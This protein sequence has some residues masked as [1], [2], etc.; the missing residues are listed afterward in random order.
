M[1]NK[2]FAIGRLINIYK[3]GDGS[4][5]LKVLILRSGHKDA[6]VNFI[7]EGELEEDIRLDRIISIEG[8]VCG[9][10][11]HREDDGLLVERRFLKADKISIAEG[12]MKKFFGIP[13]HFPPEHNLKIY[14]EGILDELEEAGEDAKRIFLKVNDEKGDSYRVALK[15]F[16]H[17]M[18]EKDYELLSVG[19][20]LACHLDVQTVKMMVDDEEKMYEY[21]MVEDFSIE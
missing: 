13:D 12:P 3:K 21:L 1:K 17:P 14:L 2:V 8:K 16:K 6:Y 20:T 9:Y 11:Y 10:S 19:Q 15:L 7:Y 5:K 18:I 4:L